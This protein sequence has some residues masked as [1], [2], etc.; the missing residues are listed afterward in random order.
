MDLRINCRRC[1]IT[2][3]SVFLASLGLMTPYLLAQTAKPAA[4]LTVGP[5]YTSSD[6][7]GAPKFPDVDLV[8]TLTGSHGKPIQPK[9][10]DLKLFS[11]GKEVGTAT[12]LRTF[13][14]S[15][16]G[17]TSILALDAS[18]SMRG[19]PLNDVHAS[20]AQFVGQA[21]AQDKVAVATFADDTRIDVP[22]DHTQSQMTTE[23]KTVKARG[24]TTRLWDGLLFALDQYEK[25]SPKRRQLIVISDGHD[26]GS[27]HSLA[28]VTR[29][30]A[31]LGV[32]IDSIGLTKDRGDY[33]KF[34]QQLSSSTEGNYRRAASAQE[35]SGLISN[36]IAAMRA[37]PVATFK[38]T[39]LASDGTR[40]PVELHWLAGQLSA[41]GSILAPRTSSDAS[42]KVHVDRL[43]IWGLCACFLAGI[44]LL[45]LSWRSSRGKPEPPRQAAHTGI[46][47]QIPPV[48]PVFPPDASL[49][50]PQRTPSAYR[51]PTLDE[52]EMNLKP[53]INPKPAL[54]PLPPPVAPSVDSYSESIPAR[55]ESRVG[56]GNRARSMTQVVGVFEA[57]EYGPFAR[58]QIK[59]GELAGQFF[60]MNTADF[61]LGALPGNQLVLPGDATV[62][63][64]H[65]RLL[66]EHGILKIEDC[67]STNGTHLNSQR[68]DAGRHLLKPGD[69]IRLGK[70][71][72]AVNR[73]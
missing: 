71:I 47:P 59:T 22:F 38:T 27:Q 16:Y 1:T 72:I 57:P 66:W 55:G 58:L 44:V 45:F 19:A 30:A 13:D 31:N 11:Q 61:S 73:I 9:P 69:E 28:D 18:G 17:V 51:S 25:A 52:S 48:A 67:K 15:G 5:T 35:L 14:K 24:K 29:K 65:A 64:R 62:S 41:P 34:L 50:A 54:K 39:N 37:T 2:L 32:V 46:P 36:G 40:Q 7:N 4:R 56:S 33:L 60:P 6:G 68:L 49:N 23:L 26:E 53:A 12:A 43:W 42:G 70:T 10:G 3:A 63:G 8:F 21:R 20:I